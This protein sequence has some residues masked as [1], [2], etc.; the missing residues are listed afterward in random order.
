VIAPLA[1][2]L[3]AGGRLIG[4][5]SYGD[6]P[7]LEIIR[8]IWPDEQPF[9]TRRRDLLQAVKAELGRDARD[10]NFNAYSDARSIFRYDMHA[11]PN[12]IQ[13]VSS[14]IGTST[15]FAAW[16]DA[17]YVAQIEDHRLEAA[18]KGSAY[19]DATREVLQRHKALWFNDESYVISRKRNAL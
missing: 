1:R 13:E 18:M 5:H 16:N 2:A 14:T 15:L 11:L 4:I 9:Q 3:R 6:D 8:K 17:A 7:G 19:L 12:E 10:F